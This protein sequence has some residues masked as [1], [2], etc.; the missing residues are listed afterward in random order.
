M[1]CPQCVPYTHTSF[2]L[3]FDFFFLFWKR[4]IV[5]IHIFF[6]TKTGSSPHCCFGRN[7]LLLFHFMYFVVFFFFLS[8]IWRN[9]NVKN[10]GEHKNWDSTH[11]HARTHEYFVLAHRKSQRMKESNKCSRE[12]SI[13]QWISC[14][15]CLR[16]IRFAQCAYI[17]IR[18]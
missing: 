3:F 4:R 7:R 14:H 11:T 17:F 18:F 13:Y 2:I 12:R 5:C 16:T 6:L 8:T 10:W 1:Y 9:R 15:L